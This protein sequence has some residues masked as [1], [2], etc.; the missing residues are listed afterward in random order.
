MIKFKEAG[1]GWYYKIFLDEKGNELSRTPSWNKKNK[2]G[3]F[4]EMQDLIAEGNEVEP[5]ETT[6]EIEER[7]KKEALE[8]LENQER[9]IIQLISKNEYH[10]ISRRFIKDLNMWIGKLDKWASQLE[11][12][13]KGNLV[14][15]EPKPEFVK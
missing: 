9:E 2:P 1:N 8:A 12:V 10:L 11:K 3:Y 7:K 6:Q 5:L 4:Q 15:I 14:K 13:Q